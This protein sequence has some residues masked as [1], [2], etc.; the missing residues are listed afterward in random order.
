MSSAT[1]SKPDWD[2]LFETAGAQEGYFTTRQ[3]AEAGYSPQLL[4]KHIRAGRVAR[5]APRHLPARP[6]PR[7]RARGAG[8]RLALVRAGRR[9][10]APDGARPP[11]ALGRAARR[12]STSRCRRPGGVGVSGCRP[13]VVLHHADVP[14]D[15][16]AWFGAVPVTQPAALAERLRA[17][18]PLAR[19][20]APGR[21]AGPSPRPRRQRPSSATS[22]QALEPF[23]GL[24]A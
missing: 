23:G 10:L 3:A 19:S 24:A 22:K 11:R 9:H 7:G 1:P 13:D 14:P 18:G 17:R 6:L 2:R 20:A 21:A 15:E 4:L 12:T 5:V 16:R 8:R